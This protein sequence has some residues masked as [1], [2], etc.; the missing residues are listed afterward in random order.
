MC[1]IAGIW[2]PGPARAPLEA[3]AQ[4]MLH[5]GP[6]DQGVFIDHQVGLAM[7]RLAVID[8]SEAAHQPM[9]IAGGDLWIV[10]NGECYNFPSLRRELES[11]GHSFTSQ[12]DTEVVLRLYQQHGGGFLTRLRGMFALA[13]YDRRQGPGRERLLVARDHLGIKPL[14][15]ARTPHGLVF[16]SELKALLA[17]G[18]VAREIDPEALRL[19]LTMGSVYQPRTML[20]GVCAL[21]PGHKLVVD[22]QGQ[23]LERYWSIAQDLSAEVAGLSYNEQVE[24]VADELAQSLRLQLV[25][26]VPI[27]AFLS[28][29]VDSSYLVGLMAAA[30]GQRVKTFSVSFLAEGAHIDESHEAERTAR[31]AGAEHTNVPITGGQVRDNLEHFI[32]GLDQP[33]VDGLNSYFISWAARQAV[34]VAISGTGGDELFAG[35]PWFAQMVQYAQRRGQPT[36][37]PWVRLWQRLRGKRTP[38]DEPPLPDFRTAYALT[39]QIFGPEGAAMMLAPELRAPAKAGRDLSQDLAPLDLLAGG[40]PVQRTTAL[41]LGGYTSNQLLRDID[42]VSMAHSLEVR[43][44]F[45]DAPLLSLALSLPPKAKIGRVAPSLD[46]VQATYRE[47]GNKRILIDAGVKRGLLPPE[48]DCQPKRGFALPFDPWLRGPLREIMEDT[49]SGP[50]VRQRGWLDPAQT[51]YVLTGFLEGKLSWA[52]PWLLMVLE[53]WGRQVLDPS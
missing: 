13:I 11:Q 5:R 2:A 6:D 46:P 8:L 36:G 30:K 34:T 15:Y 40:D 16:A 31:M 49:L 18:L 3:M 29:G 12:S 24:L 44:P 10:Y 43:V 48:I 47:C 7:R 35:Y 21:P 45:L 27:G 52:H 26:D 19:L 53:L 22:S 41:C 28:G 14:L 20:G 50:S 39:Y 9:S 38:V 33:S 25:S 4:A 1:G 17:S 23:R 51:D 37:N 42:A 32:R